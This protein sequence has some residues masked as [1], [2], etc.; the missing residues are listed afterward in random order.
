[1]KK[2]NNM[3]YTVYSAVVPYVKLLHYTPYEVLMQAIRTSH[4]TGDLMDTEGNKLGENDKKL[5]QKIIDWEHTSTL[6]HAVYTFDIAFISR[7]VLQQLARHRHISMTVKSTRFTLHKDTTLSFIVPPV[8]TQ[9]IG[10]NPE[11]TK[12]LEEVVQTVLKIQEKY[13]ND[14]AK[15]LLPE[16]VQTDLVLTVNARELAHI[17]NLRIRPQALQ[18]FQ[19]LAEQLYREVKKVHPEMWEMIAEK[20]RFKQYLMEE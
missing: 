2:V 18:E 10:N 16:A 19:E 12:L 13:G 17:I 14:V 20:Y 15:Y 7:A 11:L 6:E 1:M 4:D 9:E 8:L 5:L 3:G